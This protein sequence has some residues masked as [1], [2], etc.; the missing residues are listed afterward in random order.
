[1]ISPYIIEINKRSDDEIKTATE[2]HPNREKSKL[3]FLSI[4][5]SNGKG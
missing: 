2:D 3:N 1:M 5:K 4:Q